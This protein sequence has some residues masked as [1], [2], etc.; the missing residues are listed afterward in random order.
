MFKKKLLSFISF[1]LLASVG[2]TSGACSLVSGK[3]SSTNESNSSI[4]NSDSNIDNSSDSNGPN[5]S[6]DEIDPS[7]AVVYNYMS[8]VNLNGKTLT[9]VDN[10]AAEYSILLPAEPTEN[11][12]SYSTELND[13]IEDVSGTR[14][15]VVKESSNITSIGNYISV[16]PTEAAKKASIETA[17]IKY[18]GFVIKT[19]EENVY[20]VAR[21]ERGIQNGVYSF[22]ER[23]LGIR[24]LTARETYIPEN[25]TIQMNECDILE[26]PRFQMRDW[27][28]GDYNNIAFSAHRRYYRGDELY[29]NDYGSTHNTTDQ[30]NNSKIGYVKKV[31]IDPTDPENRT[32]GETH[33]EY[34]SDMTNSAKDYELC[35]TNGIDENGELKEGQSVASLMIDNMK[36][37]LA[38][39]AEAHQIE[40]FM[41]GH[42]DNRNAYCKCDTCEERRV[43]YTDSGIWVIFINAVEEAVNSWLMETQQRKVNFVI[44][45]YQYTYAAPVVKNADGTYTAISPICEANDNIVIRLAPIDADFTYSYT[46]PRQKE[47]ELDAVKG[48]ASIASQFML[49]DY[50]SNYIEYYWYF[51]TTHYMKENLQVFEDIGCVYAMLQSSYTQNNIWF[52]DMRN[53]IASRLFWNAN[54]DVE[55]LMNEYIELFYGPVADNVKQ[56][57]GLFENHYNELRLEEKLEVSILSEGSSF[58]NKNYASEI[59]PIGWLNRIIRTIDNAM[60][61]VEGNPEV[62]NDEAQK[63]IYKLEDIKITPMR[64]ILRN[65]ASYYS[66]ETKTEFAIEFFNLVE[67]H[68]V[69]YLGE[70]SI[71]SVA[72][73]KA[74]CGLA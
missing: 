35:M 44:F 27:M 54:W 68:G 46:D 42:V 62:S 48:W 17:N 43:T 29:C 3:D 8:G 2:F 23:F 32:L 19:V 30:A 40:Y 66:P 59:N 47:T 28:G 21:L 24:W 71:R 61:E 74:E 4:S 64:M 45:A 50:V 22:L 38:N 5:N 49:W 39:D 60:L 33:P 14:L 58:I 7:D 13:Y 12:V 70:T 10:G 67:A 9:L 6:S 53:Y 16:G 11:V 34:F 52:D 41:V 37:S 31:D 55:F 18:D 69:R 63:A 72:T 36:K 15:K 65:Y 1:L 56:I 25:R 51:P 20:I 26:E 57:V 73:R